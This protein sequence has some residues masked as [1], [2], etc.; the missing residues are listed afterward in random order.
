VKAFHQQF[1][2][3]S[4]G[5]LRSHGFFY[6]PQGERS[7]LLGLPIREPSGNMIV[8]IGGGTTEV[9]V[10]SLAGIVHSRSIRIAGDE[11]DE[12]ITAYV[13][14][15]HNLYIGDRTAEQAKIEC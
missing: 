9:A 1:Y 10:I 8:D 4:Q 3:A 12:A 7:G 6:K 5:E 15:A 13:R 14:R 2:G 11:I